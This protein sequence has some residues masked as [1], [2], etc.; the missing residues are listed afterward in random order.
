MR[1]VPIFFHGFSIS[2]RALANTWLGT[3]LPIKV[4]T[5]DITNKC[6]MRCKFCYYAREKGVHELSDNEWEEKIKEYRKRGYK[7]ALWAGGEPMVRA[8]LLKRLVSH[9][10]LNIIYTNGSW[11][12]IKLPN[13]IYFISVDGNRELYEKQRGMYYDKVK[14]NIEEHDGKV[15]IDMTINAENMDSIEEHADTWANNSKVKAVIYDMYTGE[16]NESSS[17]CLSE[18][19]KEDIVKRLEAISKKYRGKIFPDVRSLKL[20][21]KANRENVIKSCIVKDLACLDSLGDRKLPCF[22]GKSI[23]CNTCG[24]WVP[25]VFYSLYHN[26][27]VLVLF[28]FLRLVA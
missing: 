15:I 2:L 10:D 11:P 23:D 5:V 18:E 14:K 24:K 8:Q 26:M 7:F 12:L 21:L 13:T 1:I 22:F 9:F 4:L 3:N 6:N 27:N 19:Q 17:L 25:Y 28:K 20:M 16:T